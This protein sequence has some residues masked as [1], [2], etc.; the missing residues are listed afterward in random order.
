[1][2]KVQALAEELVNNPQLQREIV[3]KLCQHA[4][5]K[6]AAT[7]G[8]LSIRVLFHFEVIEPNPA[9]R[10]HHRS[11]RLVRTDMAEN[12]PGEFDLLEMAWKESMRFFQYALRLDMMEVY[13]DGK[14]IPRFI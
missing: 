1:M 7:P 2:D 10:R 9:E 3:K 5:K 8:F 6:I 11:L 14:A 13:P 12:M 4:V